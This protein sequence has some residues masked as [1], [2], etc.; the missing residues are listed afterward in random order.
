MGRTSDKQEKILAFLNDYMEEYGYA[1]SV[2]EICAAVGLKSTATVSY[3]LN[4]L[5]RQGRIEGDSSKRR[6][7][8]LPE[9][10]KVGHIPLLGVVTAGP[11]ILALEN[12]EGFVPWDGDPSCYALKIKGDSMINAGILNGDTVVV[13]PQSDAVNGEIVIALIGDEAT[14]KRFHH[15]SDGVWLLPENP[16]YDPIDGTEAVILGKVKAVIREY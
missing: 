13:R 4:E 14:C 15:G 8:S 9:S 3:H 11:P 6:A 2:R 5:K 1:P 7:I 10:R 12:I 16:A